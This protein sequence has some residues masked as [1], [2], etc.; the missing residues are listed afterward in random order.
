MLFWVLASLLTVAAVMA[1]LAPLSRRPVGVVAAG[2]FDIEVYRDQLT[3][4]DR[5]IARG[6]IKGA[7]AEEARI[8]ISRRILKLGT[9]GE[10]GTS[11]SAAVGRWAGMAAVLSVPLVAWGLYGV[12][13]SPDLPSQPLQA[14]LEADPAT[15]S[16]DELVGR[17]E[18]HLA[19][20]PEDGHGWDVLAPVYLRLGRA[21]DAVTAFQNAIRLSGSTAL[22]ESGLGEALSAVAGGVVGDDA[23]AAFERALKLE[24]GHA[25]SAFYLATAAAQRGRFTDAEAI[26]TELLASLPAQ[27][28]WKEPTEKALTE[29]KAELAKPGDSPGPTAE[30][31]AAAARMPA[32]DQLAMIESMVAQL[33]GKLQEHPQNGEGW[34]QLVRSYVVLGQIDKAQDAL[35]RGLAVLDGAEADELASIATSMGLTVTAGQ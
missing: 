18:A 19:A 27:S 11:E 31:V 8:E 4:L 30:D 25:K 23:V 1:V 34:R 6:A 21:A 3:E 35:K 13:G 24:P 32:G 26:W 17:A 9:V 5:D 15:A 29:V 20:N 10:K 28:P 22:R 14:R 12:I 33:E 2:S 16:V 7:E